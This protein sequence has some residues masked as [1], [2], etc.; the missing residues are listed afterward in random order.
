M[1]LNLSTQFELEPW[2]QDAVKAWASSHH[3]QFGN[4]HGIFD[5]FTGA[6]KT[7][8][9]F[10]AM[11]EAAASVPDLRF[12]IIVPTRALGDQWEKGILAA[13]GVSDSEVGRCPG[14]RNDSL[15]SHRFVI[16]VINTAR[17]RLAE[18]VVGEKVMLVVDECHKAGSSQNQKIFEAQTT[19]RLGLSA[20]PQREDIVDVDGYPLPVDEQ[21]HGKA[22][23]P[24]CYQLT[25]KRGRELG[26][27]P[28][29]AVHHHRITLS[30]D[31]DRQYKRLTKD[32]TEACRNMNDYGGRAEKYMAYLNGRVRGAT[33]QQSQAACEIQNTLF[34]RKQWL[35]QVSER[36]RVARCILADAA[37]RAVEAG[38]VVRAM[39]FNE[40]V[41]G[42]ENENDELDAAADQIRDEGASALYKGI[43]SDVE[44]GALNL[45]GARTSGV[46]LE[47]SRLPQPERD[48][49]V[50][51]FRRGDVRVLVSVKALVEGID[52]PDA[53]LGLSVASTSSA[54]QRIQTMGRILRA[55]RD[56]N[57]R[58]LTGAERSAQPIK[59]LHLIYVGNTV[60]AQIYVKKDWSDETGES[61]NFWWK[62]GVGTEQAEEDG[63]PPKPP[64]TEEQAWEMIKHLPMPQPWPGDANGIWWTFRQEGISKTKEGQEAVNGTEAVSLLENV[65]LKSGRDM[66]GMFKQT[67]RIFVILKST[68]DGLP[69]ACGKLSERL[70]VHED[71]QSEAEAVTE[72]VAP[73]APEAQHSTASATAEI[74]NEQNVELAEEVEK[75]YCGAEAWFDVVKCA[76]LAVKDGDPLM[77][78]SC[79][80]VLERRAKGVRFGMPW[81]DALLS[82]EAKGVNPNFDPFLA[83]YPVIMSTGIAA[84]AAGQYAVLRRCRD[85]LER[86]SRGNARLTGLTGALN[87]L[88]GETR[89]VAQGGG[90]AF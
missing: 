35:Y 39:V 48:A 36:N 22:I 70:T 46:A 16:Y 60:D 45:G 5:V 61:Q 64:P 54:R 76:F 85:E 41:G 49:A 50:M 84:Y 82:G 90:E 24:V 31:E 1:S 68:S 73:R 62:W 80:S 3:P 20:T 6:G 89:Q 10:A 51:G 28:R 29:Y 32:Y 79:R 74:W 27:L 69:L 25:L 66:R 47:H 38:R 42:D 4:R 18:H 8:L 44:T 43:C 53:D 37:A 78:T 63:E 21:P 17:N 15:A 26:M 9:A 2:Q 86:R 65:G 58:R 7:V 88:L 33:A 11:V 81:L 12:A 57:G 56:A 67:P 14:G 55:A 23:G 71:E 83:F 72:A 87:I 77:V 34:R 19:F 30:P 75:N 13:F 59:E 40:R 52:V